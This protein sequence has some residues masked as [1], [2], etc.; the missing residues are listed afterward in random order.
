MVVAYRVCPSIIQSS[1]FN[2]YFKARNIQA[3]REL[4]EQRM[5]SSTYEWL[6]RSK[7]GAATA[8]ASSAR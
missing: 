3:T 2:F 4:M 5:V 1:H 8:A 6:A 7:G